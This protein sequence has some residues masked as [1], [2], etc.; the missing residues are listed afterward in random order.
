MQPD[1]ISGRRW[2]MRTNP[3]YDPW[4]FLI[5]LNRQGAKAVGAAPGAGSTRVL[6]APPPLP[7]RDFVGI[8][9]T[10]P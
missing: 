6:G 10:P 7:Q 9:G 3:F 1:K 4:L 5:A 8:A 2:H